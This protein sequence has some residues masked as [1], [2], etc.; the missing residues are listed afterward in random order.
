MDEAEEIVMDL[1]EICERQIKQFKRKIVTEDIDSLAR[2]IDVV[3]GN[4][5]RTGR[6]DTIYNLSRELLSA[7]M[8]LC[9]SRR[10]D[11]DILIVKAVNN[12]VSLLDGDVY[13]LWAIVC[14]LYPGSLIAGIDSDLIPGL[15]VKSVF[16][17][18]SFCYDPADLSFPLDA[19]TDAAAVIVYI[20][21]NINKFLS[22]TESFYLSSIDSVRNDIVKRMADF[23]SGREVSFVFPES[24]ILTTPAL[25]LYISDYI[26]YKSGFKL[27]SSALCGGTDPDLLKSAYGNRV[28][29]EMLAE[30]KSQL[31]SVVESGAI[32]KIKEISR[33]LKI[34]P[35]IDTVFEEA[36]GCENAVFVVNRRGLSEDFVTDIATRVKNSSFYLL[37]ENVFMDGDDE[38]HLRQLKKESIFRTEPFLIKEE[39]RFLSYGFYLVKGIQKTQVYDIDYFYHSG[40]KISDEVIKSIKS[41]VISS[42]LSR[43]KFGYI[44]ARSGHYKESF[45]LVKKYYK[46]DPVISDKTLHIIMDAECDLNLRNKAESFYFSRG[47][48][49]LSFGAELIEAISDEIDDYLA[50]SKYL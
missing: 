34:V 24:G 13:S 38:L 17:S 18:D 46:A 31:G 1:F 32:P 21:E 28:Y 37:V 30:F 26:A 50:R 20:T 14:S 19:A 6:A 2:E 15:I 16:K 43:L 44:L 35:D 12:L 11:S 40:K 41:S 10:E 3:I 42:D 8:P 49:S 29:E 25:F 36:A 45:D 33:G 4:L 47:I 23:F 9:S 27:K 22:S 7:V 39:S 48:Q 5:M